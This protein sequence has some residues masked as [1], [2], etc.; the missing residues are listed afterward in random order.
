M[1]RR[2]YL[3][4]WS[5]DREL[6]EGEAAAEYAAF[7]AEAPRL[8]RFNSLAYGFYNEIVRRYPDIETIPEEDLESSPWACS[9]EFEEDYAI[10]GLLP[11][12]RH[13]VI[14]VIL[15]LADAY[16]LVCYDPQNAKVHLPR[17]QPQ[18]GRKNFTSAFGF[19]R[20]MEKNYETL[21]SAPVR[22]ELGWLRLNSPR[23][24]FASGGC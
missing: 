19:E 24:Y 3:A 9:L 2:Y 1:G 8:G 5:T 22:P 11:E 7:I 6:S 13:S 16:S 15:A 18:L 4:V 12:C 23:R 21:R 14:P 10:V 20:R 17:R